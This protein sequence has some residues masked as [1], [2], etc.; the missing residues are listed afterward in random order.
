MPRYLTYIQMDP[1]MPWGPPTAELM[2][3]IGDMGTESIK[4]GTLVDQGG[5]LPVEFGGAKIIA[6]DGKLTVHDGPYAEAK[7]V[8]GG[9]AMFE[10]RS[11]EE[12]I[13]KARQFMQAH[14]DHWPGFEGTSVVR[15]VASEDFDPTDF[16]PTAQR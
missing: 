12:A 6:K 1:S 11:K 3:A 10:L 14:I 4:D 13:E 5:L 2:Q 16:D 8:I 15:E 9:W 7:E